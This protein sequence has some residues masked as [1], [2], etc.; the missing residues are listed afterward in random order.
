[1]MDVI[2]TAAANEPKKEEKLGFISTTATTTVIIKDVPSSKPL[3]N[4]FEWHAR[5]WHGNPECRSFKEGDFDGTMMMMIMAV[6]FSVPLPSPKLFTFFYLSFKYIYT[7]VILSFSLRLLKLKVSADLCLIGLH[8]KLQGLMQLIDCHIDKTL[9]GST[10][11]R[12]RK[13][14]PLVAG[15]YDNFIK[16]SFVFVVQSSSQLY[17]DQSAFPNHLGVKSIFDHC[18][19]LA[20][21]VC[22]I[23][24][25][26]RVH[27]CTVCT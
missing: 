18:I 3:P 20:C 24:V 19:G 22:S 16:S 17:C 7:Q 23:H 5:S 9:C 10:R 27:V 1:M 11:E 21:Q 15:N 14:L 2:T 13:T 8:R 6:T 26:V 12:E 25:C 4:L